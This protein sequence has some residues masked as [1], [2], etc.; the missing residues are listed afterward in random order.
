M[1]VC[2]ECN[3]ALH[4]RCPV[5]TSACHPA[6]DLQQLPSLPLSK[7]VPD[8]R[9]DLLSSQQGLLP[10]PLLTGQLLQK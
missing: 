1:D 2:Q 6:H 5:L 9:A 3:S 7:Q 10:R 4:P 8:P